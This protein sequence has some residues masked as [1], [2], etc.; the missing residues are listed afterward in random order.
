MNHPLNRESFQL[1]ILRVWESG[2]LTSPAFQNNGKSSEKVEKL[3]DLPEK[4]LS[5]AWE[6]LVSKAAFSHLKNNRPFPGLGKSSK[7]PKRRQEKS[8]FWPSDARLIQQNALDI[9]SSLSLGE[10]VMQMR[11]LSSFLSCLKHT[12]NQV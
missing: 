5:R 11:N 1:S 10:K 8:A 12:I 2:K 3:N 7:A 6:K 4:Y 9:V